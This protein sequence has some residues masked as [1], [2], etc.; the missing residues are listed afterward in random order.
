MTFK[1]DFFE[2]FSNQ[3]DGVIYFVD[4]SQIKPSGIRSIHL[5]IPNLAGYVLRDIIY[6]PQ[7]QRNIMSLIHIR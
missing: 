1:R 6:I 3:V 2:T 5:K 4:K 7:F